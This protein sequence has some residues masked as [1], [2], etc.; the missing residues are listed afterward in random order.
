MTKNG[1]EQEVGSGGETASRPESAPIVADA[2]NPDA[3]L[4]AY[5]R[6]MATCTRCVRAGHIPE[7]NP[8]FHGYASQRLM[9]IGQ[10]PG[11]RA[12][13]TGVPWSGRSGEI[14]RGWLEQAGFPPDEWRETWYLTSLTKCFPGKATRGKGDRAPSRAEQ[15]LCA[16]HLEMELALV[17]P[18]IIVTLGKMAASRVI[19]GASR[20]PLT[21]IVGTVTDVD[22]PHGA[23]TVV[24]LPH[25][26]G[27]SRW[28]NDPANRALVDEGLAL[29]A[30]A[31]SRRKM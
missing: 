30:Q 17:R 28:L 26:S 3:L 15:T 21:D 29:L 31:K 4:E 18:E 23:T 12:H 5:Q 10:A 25:S 16:D 19:P 14:L 11:P 2:G 7:A 20:L 6:R 9:I 24:P 22:L 1:H 13:A 8:V 27:V